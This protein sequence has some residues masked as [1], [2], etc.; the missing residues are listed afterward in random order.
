MTIHDDI[1]G[2]LN[3]I[4]GLIVRPKQS[5]MQFSDSEESVKQ[6]ARKL[7]VSHIVESSVKG[8]EDNLRV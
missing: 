7:S 5:T 4:S 8:T 1:I 6:I 3:T 2:P